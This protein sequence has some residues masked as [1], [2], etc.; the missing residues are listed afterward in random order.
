[1]ACIPAKYHDS[2]VVIARRH[3][4]TSKCFKIDQEAHVNDPDYSP[5]M[6]RCDCVSSQSKISGL[7][8][9]HLFGFYS[10]SAILQSRNSEP[11]CTSW[12]LNR[13]YLLEK[14]D[15]YEA[16]TTSLFLA[17]K[18]VATKL[19]KHERETSK[20]KVKDSSAEFHIDEVDGDTF[21]IV[22]PEKRSFGSWLPVCYSWLW[23]LEGWL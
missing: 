4:S 9:F 21:R 7:Y 6:F 14:V 18:N 5:L 2:S 16:A 1:M 13:V 22:P 12:F 11:S 19:M 15:E 17:L 10:S 8:L 20:E 3:Q 23:K